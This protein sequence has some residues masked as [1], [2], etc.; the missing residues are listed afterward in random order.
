M[1]ENK[2]FVEKRLKVLK[3]LYFKTEEIINNL[4]II[5]ENKK[6]WILDL[7]F[8]DE[9]LKNLMEGISEHRPPRILLIGRTGVGKSS[10]IN[11]L[12]GAYVAKVNNTVSCTKDVQS[13]QCKEQDRV[14]LEILDSRGIAESERLIHKQSAEKQ[15]LEQ[16]VSFRPDA[17]VLMLNCTHR[18]SINEDAQF[19]KKIKKNYQEITKYRLPVIIVANKAD[20][21]GY[22]CK[23][24]KDYDESKL[25]AI[26]NFV[27][28]CEKIAM[29]EKLQVEGITAVSSYIEW[30]TEKNNRVSIEQINQL[31]SKE[32][33]KLK[34]NLDGRYQIDQ[35]KNLLE[36]AIGSKEAKAGLMLAARLEDVIRNIARRLVNIFSTISSSVALTP[37][38][39]SDIYIL[40]S[41]QI[42]LVTMIAALS[43]RDLSI[44]SAKE[45][46][47]SSSGAVGT[48]FVLR[49]IS[50]Q[51]SKLI[52]LIYPGAGSV[53][54]A[55]IAFA[56]TQAIGNAAIAYYIDG[57]SMTKTKKLFQ[58]EKRQATKAIQK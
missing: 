5:P 1:I 39:V 6:Q 10:F 55:A 47:V 16:V 31:S 25:D 12:C 50:Q 4:D 38:P 22:L 51:A 13:Y 18:D 21:I 46:I 3:D 9:E 34:I 15:L 29:N 8:K 44:N 26:T 52:N 33:A 53:V 14:L 11:A 45:F 17:A 42:I 23:E 54:S 32:I 28:F 49:M 30:K 40:T 2:D 43:G 41:L 37:I 7:I 48:G 57:L 58:Q 35:V 24:P 36:D 19:M 20:S 27:S 56:G